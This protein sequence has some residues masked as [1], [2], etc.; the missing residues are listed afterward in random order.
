P[1]VTE[2]DLRHSLIPD[3]LIESLVETMPEH[4]GPDLAEDRDLPKYD[5]ITFMQRL[6]VDGEDGTVLERGEVE[7]VQN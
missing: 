2:I 1:Y 6:M 7:E 5:Y 4:E 3:D